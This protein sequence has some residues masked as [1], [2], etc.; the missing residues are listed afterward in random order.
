MSE[1]QIGKHHSEESKRKIS[2]FFKGKPLTEETRKK[3]S[4][5]HKGKHH[6]K[7][8]NKLKGEI[9][10][11]WNGGASFLPYPPEFNGRLKQYIRDRDGNECRSPYCN[12]ENGVL[13]IRHIDYNKKNCNQCNLI[14]LCSPCNARANGNRKEWKRLYKRI[15]W[16]KGVDSK[17]KLTINKLLRKGEILCLTP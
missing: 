13:N 16:G 1:A 4:E 5:S 7:E 9:N 12:H 15:I 10:P 2:A 3:M 8:E 11:N 6:W 14:T 17:N